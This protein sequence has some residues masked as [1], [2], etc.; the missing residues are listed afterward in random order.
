MKRGPPLNPQIPSFN[1]NPPELL[2][3]CHRRHLPLFCPPPLLIALPR[4]GP[5][6][7]QSHFLPSDSVFYFKSISTLR[8][9]GGT[10]TNE[11]LGPT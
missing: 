4:T 1:T 8:P 3:V 11:A 10:S 5:N 7:L 6:S 9:R 2:V